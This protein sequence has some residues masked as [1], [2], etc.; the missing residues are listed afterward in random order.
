MLCERKS[1][2]ELKLGIGGVSVVGQRKTLTCLRD[3]EIEWFR[4]FS[5]AAISRAIELWLLF[6]RDPYS[7]REEVRACLGVGDL[8]RQNAEHARAFSLAAISEVP[9]WLGVLEAS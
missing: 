7:Y 9:D 3:I 5:P 1:L 2:E 6:E 4:F 8:D